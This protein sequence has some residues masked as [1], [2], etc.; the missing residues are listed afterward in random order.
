MSKQR[1]NSGTDCLFLLHPG[2]LTTRKVADVAEIHV[3]PMRKRKKLTQESIH[4]QFR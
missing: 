3:N 4:T 1:N 2:I